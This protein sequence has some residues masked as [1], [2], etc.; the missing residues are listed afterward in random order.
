MVTLGTVISYVTELS[1]EVEALLRFPAA[2]DALPE[3]MRAITVPLP[4]MPV[5]ATLYVRPLPVT[6]ATLT[7]GA[8]PSMTTSPVTKLAT[9]SLK[10]TVKLIGERL[11]G[12]ACLAA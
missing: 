8:V 9:D 3:G 4:V 2:S 10:T 6:V 12:S 7:P 5:T 11:V 1:V